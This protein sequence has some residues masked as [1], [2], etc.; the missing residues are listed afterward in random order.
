MHQENNKN[1]SIIIPVYNEDQYIEKLFQDL[2]KFFNNTKI[3]VIF[4]ND[5]SYD[6][7]SKVLENLKNNY[8]FLFSLSI[9]NL[10]NH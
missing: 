7:S 9:I 4:I 5:G 2:L 1:L 10:Q 8:K 3:E 6:N